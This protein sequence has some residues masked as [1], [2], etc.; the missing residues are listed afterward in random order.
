MGLANSTNF[1]YFA[2]ELLD[3]YD[4]EKRDL[5]W[6]RSK[7]PYRIWV[8]EIMLQQTRVETVIPYYEA[9]MEKFP[10]LQALADAPEEEVLKAW[11]GLGYYSRA[12][13]LHSAV[14]DVCEL[15][16]GEVPD[17]PQAV[18]GLRGVG[19]YTAGAILSIAFN[20]PEPAV[21]G[22]VMRVLSRFFLLEDD[23]AKPATR[24]KIEG[25][26]RRIIPQGRP[27]DFNQA[28]MDLGATVCTPKSPG[29]LTC[30]VMERC[31]GRL[32][33]RERELPVKSKAKKPR[34]EYRAVALIEGTG[35]HK[36][37]LLIRQRPPSGLLA[38]LWELPHVRLQEPSFGNAQAALQECRMPDGRA[39]VPYEPFMDIEHVFSHIRWIMRVYL[40]RLTDG[41]AGPDDPGRARDGEHA[42]QSEPEVTET[43]WLSP[44]DRDAYPFPNVFVRIL[45]EYWKGGRTE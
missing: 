45:D 6:R 41:P 1:Q 5:P 2:E 44:D 10:T 28:L 4:R 43:R 30:P 11:E 40:A 24:V 17:D 15:Y 31:E 22:N 32:K 38:G 12:R 36:G 25:L 14:R 26:V 35:E 42:G 33:G 27:G 3:W 18:S 39:V 34:P 20:R 37:K 29:C 9:F 21:D 23:V 19:P 13:N 7:D 16:G 8:S